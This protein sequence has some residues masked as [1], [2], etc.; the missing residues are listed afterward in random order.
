MSEKLNMKRTTINTFLKKLL[1]PLLMGLLTQNLYA[2]VL[3]GSC[4]EDPTPKECWGYSEKTFAKCTPEREE[5]LK[6]IC[7]K[8]TVGA[9]GILKPIQSCEQPPSVELCDAY[10]SKINLDCGEDFTNSLKLLCETVA[11]SSNNTQQSSCRTDVKEEDCSHYLQT[12]K[13]P[14][15]KGCTLKE[16]QH[17]IN[18]CK[19]QIPTVGACNDYNRGIRAK[20]LNCNVKEEKYCKYFPTQNADEFKPD[21]SFVTEKLCQQYRQTG[22]MAF[23]KSCGEQEF[24][25]R[26]AA[27]E[28]IFTQLPYS[29]EQQ[30]KQRSARV[31]SSQQK[32]EEKVQK[33]PSQAVLS[34]DLP[35][36]STE[37][38]EVSNNQEIF[39][40]LPYSSDEEKE[41][42]ITLQNHLAFLA[43]LQK[44]AIPE[45][46][47]AE[48][49]ID[50]C[51]SF[52]AG[53][54]PKCPT[55]YLEKL[56]NLCSSHAEITVVDID[57]N[58]QKILSSANIFIV[59]ESAQDEDEILE[60]DIITRCHHEAFL[61]EYNHLFST[62][63]SIN[64]AGDT[65]DVID[66]NFEELT[67]KV[68]E[69][70][71]NQVSHEQLVS[72]LFAKLEA[73]TLSK[74]AKEAILSMMAAIEA[75]NGDL[76]QINLDVDTKNL[77]EEIVSD[78]KLINQL[79]IDA[80]LG[81]MQADAMKSLFVM[82]QVLQEEK[83]SPNILQSTEVKALL[84]SEQ[85][86]MAIAAEF[87]K[88][89]KSL[90]NEKSADL[91]TIKTLQQVAEGQAEIQK[92]IK[93]P[94]AVEKQQK[95]EGF[96]K[97]IYSAAK[98][99]FIKASHYTKEKLAQ[100][101]QFSKGK[102]SKA[103][104]FSKEKLAKISEKTA[105][106][107]KKTKEKALELYQKTKENISLLLNKGKSKISSFK[108]ND[109][110]ALDISSVLE[111][112][113]VFK[114]KK[115]AQIHALTSPEKTAYYVKDN[116]VYSVN[117]DAK[118]KRIL[119]PMLSIQT[120]VKEKQA[121]FVMKKVTNKEA[122]SIYADLKSY[123][124]TLDEKYKDDTTNPDY[125]IELH[126]LNKFYS[127]AVDSLK[128]AK[129]EGKE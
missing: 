71:H 78:L 42:K 53:I 19:E 100:L 2:R 39:T 5:K 29:S 123:K 129:K 125:L 59:D 33:K 14:F 4:D 112:P 10:K 56:K 99:K 38:P 126:R 57:L 68:A 16:Q 79:K 95:R 55:A 34:L 6:N 97:N 30:T 35:E 64:L 31:N 105:P 85:T 81:S 121:E 65:S 47:I 45:I 51:K 28:A 50:Q 89:E 101:A 104:D 80:I 62:A 23:S 114:S 43:E 11:S 90:N 75:S 13:I 27:N 110:E 84:R 3:I 8:Y 15:I 124:Q 48:P 92:I 20:C 88:L 77:P 67:K 94:E 22:E 76:A 24:K 49:A 9:F 91:E 61:K 73:G 26:C 120:I 37:R 127:L 25:N 93:D 116:K 111:K 66:T 119:K 40:E 98:D 72:E 70:E 69:S 107:F 87:E 36:T 52:K 7:S 44:P 1:I 109:K 118:I 86:K 106:I 18:L 17:L 128:T 63:E 21:C 103:K 46:C 96:F 54:Y 115:E 58:N 83:K 32:K 74:E 117:E 122:K 102:F 108:S 60:E 12:G 41:D 82:D 113:A